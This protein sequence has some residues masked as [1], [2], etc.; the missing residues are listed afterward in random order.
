MIRRRGDESRILNSCFHKVAIVVCFILLV[1]NEG[2]V[3]AFTTNNPTINMKSAL[4]S[5]NMV[6]MS[7][8]PDQLEERLAHLEGSAP[9]VFSKDFTKPM[10]IPQEGIDN[11]VEVLKT[12]N[13]QSSFRFVQNLNLCIETCTFL[14]T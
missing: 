9:P 8:K 10:S 12:G 14:P 6:T 11:V 3:S 7:P 1:A 2:L 4:K 5:L 13:S